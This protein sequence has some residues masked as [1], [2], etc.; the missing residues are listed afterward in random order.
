VFSLLNAPTQ[1]TTTRADLFIP[2]VA[3]GFQIRKSCL[4]KQQEITN[5]RWYGNTMVSKMG[6][7][8]LPAHHR[9]RRFDLAAPDPFRDFVGVETAGVGFVKVVL[10]TVD[11]RRASKGSTAS[12]PITSSLP[13]AGMLAEITR[14][15]PPFLAAFGVSFG[16]VYS[17]SCLASTG[18][19]PDCTNQE[20]ELCQNNYDFKH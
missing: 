13:F 11:L 14:A 17:F 5:G 19:T 20:I 9:L 4:L 1:S 15:L 12:C 6:L 18:V 10:R 2:W 8:R 7:S 16:V 3:Q